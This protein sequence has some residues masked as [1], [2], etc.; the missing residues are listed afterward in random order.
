MSHRTCL[1]GNV[2]VVQKVVTGSDRA[3]GDEGGAIR[4]VRRVLEHTMPMLRQRSIRQQDRENRTGAVTY[5][6]SRSQ[7]GLVDQLVD[8][9]DTEV[10]SL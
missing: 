2:E 10:V 7:H 8:D 3:L 6:G 5:D 1:V 4:P 9:V